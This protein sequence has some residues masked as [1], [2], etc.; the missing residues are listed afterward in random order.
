MSLE[1]DVGPQ[2]WRSGNA[3]YKRQPGERTPKA[4]PEG[5][6]CAPAAGTQS[7]GTFSRRKKLQ[8]PVATEQR[9]VSSGSGQAPATGGDAVCTTLSLTFLLCASALV[10]SGMVASTARSRGAGS[11]SDY[12]PHLPGTGAPSGARPAWGTG[13]PKFQVSS[14]FWLLPGT[15]PS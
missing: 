1:T 2:G 7:S 9:T 10:E 5:L 15:R 11:E 8:G 6:S 14:E 12:E 13:N 3:A 4:S